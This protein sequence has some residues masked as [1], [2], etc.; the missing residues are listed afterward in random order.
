VIGCTLEGAA[1]D[2]NKKSVP[3]AVREARGPFLSPKG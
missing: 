1:S 3:P 2:L